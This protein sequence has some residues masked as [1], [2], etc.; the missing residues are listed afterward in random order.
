[1]DCGNSIVY[2]RCIGDGANTAST[3]V[4][5]ADR[6]FELCLD[7]GQFGANARRLVRDIKRVARHTRGHALTVAGKDLDTIGRCH[8]E[9]QIL[10]DQG[11]I[12][13]GYV[14]MTVN[15]HVDV[16]ERD[17][18]G[19]Q[20]KA[21]RRA[22][23]GVGVVTIGCER[24]GR[25]DLGQREILHCCL[26]LVPANQG[27][28]LRRGQVARGVGRDRRLHGAVDR[29]AQLLDL[30]RQPVEFVLQCGR[31]ERAAAW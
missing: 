6:L 19:R 2:C 24:D 17:R 31:T 20:H 4:F 16:A 23:P 25:G 5:D 15:R 1:M 26:A 22:I 28:G 13:A 14:G 10:R 9:D 12:D 7:R 29:F 27:V 11:V 18:V 3:K 21:G 30:H 8:G